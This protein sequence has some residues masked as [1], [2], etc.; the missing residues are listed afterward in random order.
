M[1]Y[2]HYTYLYIYIIDDIYLRAHNVLNIIYYYYYY[3]R[4]SS[5][6]GYSAPVDSNT[7]IFI[8]ILYVYT[9]PTRVYYYIMHIISGYAGYGDEQ[10]DPDHCVFVC[11][12]A[13]KNLLMNVLCGCVRS[14]SVSRVPV[15]KQGDANYWAAHGICIYN[16]GR[17]NRGLIHFGSYYLNEYL[18]SK[19]LKL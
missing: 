5:T 7:L 8:P 14:A 4:L 15:Q 19:Y 16:R 2:I 12:R 18:K 9:P 10:W 1:A 17:L 11:A 13:Y 3:Y 6:D